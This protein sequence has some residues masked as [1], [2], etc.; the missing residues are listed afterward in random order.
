[1]GIAGSDSSRVT[2]D[3]VP[4]A[5]G[6]SLTLVHELHPAWSAYAERTQAGWTKMFTALAAII[7]E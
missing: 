1:M 4:A 6:C 2:V 5:A 7:D 3:I